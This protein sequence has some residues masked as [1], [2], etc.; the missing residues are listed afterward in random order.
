M[1]KCGGSEDWLW[2]AG[3]LPPL[4]LAAPLVGCR[5]QARHGEL[6]RLAPR[7]GRV[8]GSWEVGCAHV[9]WGLGGARSPTTGH[10]GS[11]RGE[12]SVQRAGT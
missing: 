12:R 1:R 2:L 7:A 6:V 9:G 11:Q 10:A 5:Y 3:Q 4:A 8:M